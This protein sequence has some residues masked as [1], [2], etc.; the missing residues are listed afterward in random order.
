MVWGFGLWVQ[1][2]R[3][4]AQ[5]SGSRGCL[6]LG[7]TMRGL[8]IRVKDFRVQG[9]GLWANRAILGMDL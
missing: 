7:F 2:S 4:R 3:F 6:C 9:F 8:E 5:G 1:S